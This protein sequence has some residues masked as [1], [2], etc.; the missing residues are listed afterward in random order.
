[1]PDLPELIVLRVDKRTYPEFNRSKI[2][3][4]YMN[5]RY[6]SNLIHIDDIVAEPYDYYNHLYTFHQ[7][8]RIFPNKLSFEEM[9]ASHHNH[10]GMLKRLF[11][12][13]IKGKEMDKLLNLLEITTPDKV[14]VSNLFL[15]LKTNYTYTYEPHLYLEC[16]NHELYEVKLSNT[17]NV[18][19]VDKKRRTHKDIKKLRAI[20]NQNS[21]E[22]TLK[23]LEIVTPKKENNA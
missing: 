15:S 14:K 2:D 5:P 23:I 9:I 7:S 6:A 21:A 16:S 17:L 3:T 4:G 11:L 12:S 8:I 20:I 1:M 10:R 18:K 19:L 13:V 22:A